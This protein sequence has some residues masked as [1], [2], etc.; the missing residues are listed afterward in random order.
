MPPYS[1]ARVDRRGALRRMGAGAALAGGLIGAGAWFGWSRR[2]PGLELV[3]WNELALGLVPL[4]LVH[5]RRLGRA[6]ASAE[7][8]AADGPAIV[9]SL[10]ELRGLSWGESG[11][12]WRGAAWTVPTPIDR[13]VREQFA[14]GRVVVVESWVL[15][16][17]EAALCA[18]AALSVPSEASAGTRPA[19]VAG[20]V[21]KPDVP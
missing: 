6:F 3:T 14:A 19:G 9:R 15:S 5:V 18:I 16:R 12:R 2:Q 17:L 21:G 13:A 10:P 7:F 20:A 4:E 1:Q 8:P 11:V